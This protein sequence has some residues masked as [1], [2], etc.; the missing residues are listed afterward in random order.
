ML[1]EDVP[2]RREELIDDV[3]VDRRPVGGDLNRC[4]AGPARPGEQ[5]PSSSGV[6]AF[7]DQHVDDLAVLV[8]RSVQVDPPAATFT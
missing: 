4:R 1:L 3:G 5:R 8:D 2:C 7:G 6:A